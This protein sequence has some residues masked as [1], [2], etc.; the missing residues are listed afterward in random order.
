MA[1]TPAESDADGWIAQH[2]L[3]AFVLCRREAFHRSALELR[4]RELLWDSLPHLRHRGEDR[5]EDFAPGSSERVSFAQPLRRFARARL[6]EY[7]L[8]LRELTLSKSLSAEV[9]IHL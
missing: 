2:P 6:P 3:L 8:N 1:G 7:R 9:G 5:P 4:R